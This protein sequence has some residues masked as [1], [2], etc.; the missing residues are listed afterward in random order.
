MVLLGVAAAAAAV[1]AA[2]AWLAAGWPILLVVLFVGLLAGAVEDLWVTWRG[3]D[4]VLRGLI[5]EIWPGMVG[6]LDATDRAIYGVI[7][8]FSMFLQAGV[9]AGLLVSGIFATIG[10]NVAY[11]LRAIEAVNAALGVLVGGGGV[12]AAAGTAERVMLRRNRAGRTI[13]GEQRL[14]NERMNQGYTG[15]SLD[16]R[17]GGWRTATA[18]A[19]QQTILPERFRPRLES[20]SRQTT[21]A[22][23]KVDARQTVTVTVNEATDAAETER[24]IARAIRLENEKQARLIGAHLVPAGGE[25]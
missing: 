9:S 16:P 12:T 13:Q 19:I 11:V 6:G 8:A 24:R 20:A 7:A 25:T 10:N 4:S 18:R 22:S 21:K 14:A 23:T 2:V 15:M 3:G 17:R 1:R 5:N